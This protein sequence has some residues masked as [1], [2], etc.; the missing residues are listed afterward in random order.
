M[1]HNDVF[2]E[3][4]MTRLRNFRRRAAGYFAV[5]LLCG[6][7]V[8]GGLFWLQLKYGLQP[9]QRI[10]LKSYALASLKT[11]VSQ[12]SQAKYVMLVRTTGDP[13][14]EKDIRSRVTDDEVEPV[15]DTQGKIVRDPKLGWAFRLKPGIPHKYFYW[16]TGRGKDTEMYEWMRTHIYGGASF[17]RLCLPML[18]IGAGVFFTGLTWTIV[19]DRRSNKKYEQG[20]PIRGT[21]LLTP[22]EYEREQEA[23]TGI[24]II[25][26]ERKERAA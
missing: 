7:V 26:Y 22:K 24:G 9:L 1:N 8:G 17:F 16:M 18:I 21:R 10:Y 25:V 13:A 23:A 11:T 19:R 12:R 2:T 20:R 3:E 4:G 15:L 6:F 5:W 14:T